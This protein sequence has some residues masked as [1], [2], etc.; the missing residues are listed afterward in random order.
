MLKGLYSAASGMISGVNRQAVLTHNITNLNTPGFKQ[1][2]LTM[3]D[4]KKTQVS[5]PTNFS[6]SNSILPRI[7]PTLAVQ[8]T[9]PLGQIGLG[10][11]NPAETYDFSQGALTTTNQ[12]LDMAIQGDG[13]FEVQT[14]NGNRY[15]RDGRFH[16]DSNHN[17]VT[18]DSNFVLDQN[19]NKITLP[20]GEVS[21]KGDGT[22]SVGAQQVVKLGVFSFANP[23]TDLTRDENMFVAVG[24]PLASTGQVS[25]NVLESSNADLTSA[26]AQ[27]LSIGR[28]YDAAQQMVTQQD[29]LLGKS[30]STLGRFT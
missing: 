23:K 26:M 24:T 22:I 12:P 15:T 16:L 10:V 11:L 28:S 8:G 9:N 25:N 6:T 4:W 18:V 21:V 5:D 29:T 19:G 20:N 14:P 3:E 2:L 13:F 27:M 30:I 17:L 1:V 7:F